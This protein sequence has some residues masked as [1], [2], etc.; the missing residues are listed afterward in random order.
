MNQSRIGAKLGMKFD[1]SD[2]GALS[3]LLQT[4]SE[5]YGFMELDFQG[6]YIGKTKPE[7]ISITDPISDTFK[8]LIEME[9]QY[10]AIGL[11]FSYQL[12]TTDLAGANFSSARI[13]TINDN[14]GFRT[15]YKWFVKARC[16]KRWEK[17]RMGN[18]DW[19]PISIRRNYVRI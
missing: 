12:F 1:Q 16:Q 3:N 10:I 2:G 8:A 13:N 15:L 19:T 4:S 9:M 11:G 18:Y 6:G 7:P 14:A 17:C 5:G